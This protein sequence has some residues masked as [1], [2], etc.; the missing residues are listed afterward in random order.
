MSHGGDRAA[1]DI[2]PPVA[3][4]PREVS[5][6]ARHRRPLSP[7]LVRARSLKVSSI[8]APNRKSRKR[9]RRRRRRRP[10]HR[11]VRPAAAAPTRPIEQVEQHRAAQPRARARPQR[12]RL[13]GRHSGYCSRTSTKRSAR[14]SLQT[15]ERWAGHPRGSNIRYW[16]PV[17]IAAISE[18][19]INSLPRQTTCRSGRT[20]K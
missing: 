17:A 11:I 14:H 1:D 3:G 10:H 2:M 12:V 16:W 13:T 19:S 9:N 4:L 6:P 8:V 20:S 18:T 7:L 15:R 5:R